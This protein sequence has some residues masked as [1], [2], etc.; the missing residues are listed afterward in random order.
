MADTNLHRGSVEAT[1][2]GAYDARPTDVREA[3]EYASPGH[4]SSNDPDQLQDEIEHLQNRMAE[5]LDRVTNA[6]TPQNLIAQATGE[7]NPD[8]FTTL[9]TVV[10]T[11]KRNPLAAGLIGAGLVQ[12]LMSTRDSSPEPDPRAAMM[13]A[14]EFGVEGMTAD[15]QVHAASGREHVDELGREETE[16]NSMDGLEKRVKR[17]QDRAAVRLGAATDALSDI[18]HGSR[19]YVSNAYGRTR[20]TLVRTEREDG[21]VEPGAVD[22]VKENPIPIGLAALAAGALAAGYYTASRP[23]PRYSQVPRDRA[24]VPQ[25]DM[26]SVEDEYIQRH[27]PDPVAM[28]VS[29]M[30]P[31]PMA[32]GFDRT[33]AVGGSGQIGTENR[34]RDSSD[35]TADA[36]DRT[37]DGEAAGS[38]V[39][40]KERA[41]SNA[42][43]GS[44]AASRGE[45]ASTPSDAQGMKPDHESTTSSPSSAEKG[46]SSSMSAAAGQRGVDGVTLHRT[47]S[48]TFESI[49]QRAD[50]SP[51]LATRDLTSIYRSE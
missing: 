6:F 10:D 18:Y 21:T 16:P 19:G 39:R 36:K 35:A 27:E 25:D 5:R 40:S 49:P 20:S 43:F 17:L 28:P 33:A 4:F 3:D 46:P 51:S 22:W 26:L 13:A 45:V 11:A 44:T 14:G 30:A 15:G 42:G 31:T 32:G 2:R 7:R 8:L 23:A 12:L 47:P 50:S 37:S 38:A 24:L 41:P 1:R 29:A 9:D 34:T 48:D